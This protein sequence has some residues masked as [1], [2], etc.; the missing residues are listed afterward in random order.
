MFLLMCISLYTSREILHILGIVDFGIYSVVGGV[1][2]LFSFLS[3]SM[4]TATQRFLNFE[5]AKNNKDGLREIFAC[6]FSIHLLLGLAVVILCET[7]GLWFVYNKLVI[8]E[9]RFQT[10]LWIYHLSVFATLLSIMSLPYNAV[11]IAREKMDAFAGISILEG[12]FKLVLVLLLYILPFDKLKLYACLILIIQIVVNF[13]YVCYCRNHFEEVREKLLFR[14]KQFRD[15]LI[16]AGWDMFG[17]VASVA[18]TIGI[19]MLLNVFFGPVLNAARNVTNQVV[20]NTIKFANNFQIAA[21]PQITKAYSS[22]NIEYMH[23]LICSSAKFSFI[24]IWIFALPIILEI[25]YILHLWLVEV[26]PY[27][28]FFIRLSFVAVLV[29]VMGTPFWIATTSTGKIKKFEIV[30]NSILFMSLP[31]SYIALKLGGSPIMVY[32]VD[33]SIVIL[34]VLSQIIIASSLVKLPKLIFFKKVFVSCVFVISISSIIPLSLYYL[35]PQSFLRLIL[36]SIF[37]VISVVFLTYHILTPYEKGFVDE[38]I[39][40]IFKH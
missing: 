38:K 31:L 28:P 3:Y 39:K 34:K 40:Y 29:N 6:S 10:A 22:G 12:I 4:V 30:S 13:I 32:I 8:P 15:I 5:M 19:D 9:M 18:C 1:V 25:Q 11:I 17:N 26:P 14:G 37:S 21:N 23:K 33:V 2:G 7:I 36:I 24:L 27:S 20:Q 35:M 16:F